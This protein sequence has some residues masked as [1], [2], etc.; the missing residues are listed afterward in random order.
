MD[1]SLQTRR[2]CSN[3]REMHKK[4]CGGVGLVIIPLVLS[5]L[6]RRHACSLSSY[7]LP[8]AFQWS[9]QTSEK[10]SRASLADVFV[11]KRDRKQGRFLGSAVHSACRDSIAV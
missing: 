10:Q 5:E 4:R 11:E 7:P 3:S 6:L 9:Y 2:D 8:P 1:G